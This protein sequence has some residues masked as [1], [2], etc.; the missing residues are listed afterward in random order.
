[1]IAVI[2]GIRATVRIKMTLPDRDIEKQRKQDEEALL[3]AGI[4]ISNLGKD[5]EQVGE[6]SWENSPGEEDPLDARFRAYYQQKMQ[7][8]ANDNYWDKVGLDSK[9]FGGYDSVSEGE[10]TD[11]QVVFSGCGY[12]VARILGPKTEVSLVSVVGEDALGLAA[13]CELE[14]TGV[15]ILE[16]KTLPGVT[17]VGVEILNVLG[18][19]D[20]ARENMKLAK[21]ITPQLIDEAAGTLDTAESIFVDGSIPV[22][23]LNYISEKYAGSC[24]IYFDPG[25]ISGGY[26]YRD[27]SLRASCVMPG[28]MEAEAM[29]GQQVLGPDQL[30]AAGECFE[31]RGVQKTVI[32]LKGGGL[33]YKE[34]REAGIIKPY[35]QY[36]SVE[37]RGAG[38]VASARLVYELVNGR[39]LRTAAESAVSAAGEYIGMKT[40]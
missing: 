33:Y 30:M 22:E 14:A 19:I 37:T 28:R 16:V 26:A 12:N 8:Q 15:N 10:E 18:D 13:K 39:D 3:S 32:T 34:G 17:P 7:E 4:D 6:V 31:A 29:S 11:I 35:E 23:T 38:D 27:S 2:S 40:K 1:M 25:S 21:E 9:N 20:F 36:S 24:P 5:T